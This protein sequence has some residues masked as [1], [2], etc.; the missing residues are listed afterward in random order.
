SAITERLADVEQTL[1]HLYSLLDTLK[2]HREEEQQDVFDSLEKLEREKQ[3]LMSE[4]Q[5]E[6]K[7]IADL[8]RSYASLKHDM[9]SQTSKGAGG[10]GVSAKEMQ[11]IKR[12]VE[13]LARDITSA[14]AEAVRQSKSH[15]KQLKEYNSKLDNVSASAQKLVEQAKRALEDKI[16]KLH[17]GRRVVSGG[18]SGSVSLREVRELVDA[19]IREQEKE[20]RELLKP[21]WLETDGDVAYDNVARMI[22]GALN[23]YANDRVGK[24]DFAL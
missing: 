17:G 5:D 13:R 18:G 15:D 2:T 11:S 24:T 1:R 16:S 21:E 9:Q 8:E 4:H 20:L 23:R 14:Q 6:K 19:A 10:S 12:Q 3:Q 7:R 22:E